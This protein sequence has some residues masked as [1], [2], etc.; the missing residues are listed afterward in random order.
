MEPG[1]TFAEV[2]RKNSSDP[3]SAA[4]GGDLDFHPRGDM[5]AAF[6]DVMFKLKPGEISD[7]VETDFGYH[8]ITVTAV[9]GG[10]VKPFAEARAEVEAEARKAAALKA[11]GAAA[12][13]F[14]DLAFT[15]STSLQ[16]IVDKLK[17]EKK[18]ATV[19]RKAP[20]GATGPLASQKLLDAIFSNEVVRDKRNTDGIE[21]APMS[22]FVTEHPMPPA[23]LLG[24][25]GISADCR[26]LAS[27]GEQFHLPD[28]RHFRY[29]FGM[30]G[31]PRFV[32]SVR[33]TIAPLRISTS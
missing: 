14:S 23:L 18:T 26:T 10:T 15:Q 25:S 13:S 28:G 3:G 24:F 27:Y 2:A 22:R 21:V 20:A 30:L 11:W 9:R 12:E 33:L 29:P 6:D 32:A 1:A 4:Q 5:V 19:A 31:S 8:I 16:P 17:L 7:V